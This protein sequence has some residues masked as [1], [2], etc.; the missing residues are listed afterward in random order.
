MILMRQEFE[1]INFL[2]GNEKI[3]EEMK[4]SPALPIF[5]SRILEFFSDLSNFLLKDGRSRKSADLTAFA[6]WIRKNSLQREKNL[7]EKIIAGKETPL[8]ECV[9]I[10]EGKW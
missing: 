5:Y 8:D 6:Y 4:F 10:D 7:R 9:S 1:K 2:V 3:L